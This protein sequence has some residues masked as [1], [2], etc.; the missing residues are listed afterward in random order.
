MTYGNIR[1]IVSISLCNVF[2]TLDNIKTIVGVEKLY[3][4]SGQYDAIAM[5]SIPMNELNHTIDEIKRIKGV[6]ATNTILILKEI[7]K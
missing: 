5:I 4:V 3:E 7:K 2:F 6:T 1:V